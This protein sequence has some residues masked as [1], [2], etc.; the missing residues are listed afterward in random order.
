MEQPKEYPQIQ[1]KDHEDI[2]VITYYAMITEGGIEWAPTLTSPIKYTTHSVHTQLNLPTTIKDPVMTFKIVE[3]L[4]SDPLII[5]FKKAI[6]LKHT[7]NLNDGSLLTTVKK[8]GAQL[9]PNNPLLKNKQFL[10]K[11]VCAKNPKLEKNSF[12][13]QK[14]IAK[15]SFY[16]EPST[17]VDEKDS[18]QE[19]IDA[20]IIKKNR[21]EQTNFRTIN[22]VWE[23]G[24]KYDVFEHGPKGI[25][26]DKALKQSIIEEK[27]SQNTSCF[28]ALRQRELTG[29][30]KK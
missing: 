28:K 25:A 13:Q 1:L 21:T 30:F 11:I 26:N 8:T 15:E 9:Y 24:R 4:N 16:K 23:Q 7:F 2:A 20:E 17:W 18:I 5:K 22:G 10:V 3:N 6:P 29:S 27:I 12:A 14:Y 19:L